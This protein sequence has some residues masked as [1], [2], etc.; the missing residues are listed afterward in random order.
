MCCL[1]FFRANQPVNTLFW[2]YQ[3]ARK[4]STQ[5]KDINR[6]LDSALGSRTIVLSSFKVQS[7]S[8]YRT[9]LVRYS[10]GDLK[11]GLIKA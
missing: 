10:I 5:V 6:A 2:K 9:S 7:P 4:F 1:E 8:E 11:T 3:L